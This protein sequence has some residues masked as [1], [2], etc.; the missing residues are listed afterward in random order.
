MTAGAESSSRMVTRVL[1]EAAGSVAP[2]VGLLRVTVKVSG[3]SAE[4]SW[5]TGMVMVLKPASP[6]A[7]LRVPVVV[8]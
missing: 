6:A 7:Q 8:V 4:A 5:V 3:D 2:P 1:A